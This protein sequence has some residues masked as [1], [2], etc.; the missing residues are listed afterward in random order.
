MPRQSFQLAALITITFATY[1]PTLGNGFIWDDDRYIEENTQLR[2]LRGL[3]HIWFRPLSAEPQYY[4]LTHTM[5]GVEYH[6]WGPRAAGYHIDNL[7]LHTA[8]AVLLWR[9]LLALDMPGAWVIA[10]IFAVHPLQVESVAWA[11][12]RKNVLSGVLYLSALGAYLSTRWGMRIVRPSG[13]SDPLPAPPPECQRMGNA[14][15][16]AASL[17]L[18]VAAILSKSVASSLPAVILLLCWWKRGRITPAE[19]WPV[20]PMFVMGIAMGSLT[21]W[22]EKHVVGA[23]GPEYDSLTQ[24]DRVCIA[25]RA[26]WFYLGKLVW[27]ASLSFIYPRWNVDPL[28]RSWWIL[29]PL[30][31]IGVLIALWLLRNRIGRGPATASFFYLG[32]LVPALGFVNVFPMRYSYVADHFQYLACI[33]P[34][35]LAVELV[36][37]IRFVRI[38]LREARAAIAGAVIAALC[39]TTSLR[40]TAFHNRQTLWADTLLKNPTSPMVHNNYAGALERAGQYDAAKAQYEEAL[41]LGG[42]S[43][44]LVGVGHCYAHQGDFVRAREMYQK[45]LDGLQTTDDPVSRHYRAGRLLELGTAYQGL[46]TEFPGQSAQYLSQAEAAYRDAIDLFPEYED[47]HGNLAIV[48]A[49]E[50]KYADAV[51]ECRRILELNPDSVGARINMGAIYFDQGR[52][53]ESLDAYRD[54]LNVE[55][56]NTSALTSIGGILGMMGRYDEAIGYFQQ[57][58]R[59]DPNNQIAKRNLGIALGKKARQS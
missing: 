32:T 50:K 29:F 45:A 25:G 11:T 5:L 6:L 44:N 59:I 22:M 56:N 7:L 43:I 13:G 46:A 34:I 1:A 26:F 37:R 33:G 23:M 47:L 27:P 19:V 57:V 58:L 48:L 12:E 49:D 17:V 15:W 42:D 35:A 2:T 55:P 38:P 20:V 52:L 41:R 8:S 31:A 28:E 36:G 16:Y 51:D 21:G 54:V 4:P 9:I 24:L 3:E 18:F 40:S 10:A 39:V 14:G 30:A 53:P